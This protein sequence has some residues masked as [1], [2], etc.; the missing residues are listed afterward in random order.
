MPAIRQILRDVGWL[1]VVIA[2]FAVPFILDTYGRLTYLTSLTLW[3]VPILYLWPLFRSLTAKGR[4]R[5]R[6]ALRTSVLTL[7]TFGA[8]LDILVGHLTFRFSSCD[9]YTYCIPGPSGMVPIEELLFYACG[10]AGL[11]RSRGQV[12]CGG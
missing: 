3:L 6:R 4:G 1:F 12:D 7:L 9:V 8:L 10:P 2:T 5:R 11:I